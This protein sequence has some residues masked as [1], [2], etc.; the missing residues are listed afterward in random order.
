MSTT[1]TIRETLERDLNQR[2]EEIIKLDQQDERSDVDRRR[3]G[4][5]HPGGTHL[6][7]LHAAS[8]LFH[9]FFGSIQLFSTS[10]QQ[11]DL[12]TLLCEL[13]CSGPSNTTGRTG[14]NN[15]LVSEFVFHK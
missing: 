15:Y 8:N 2:I 5:A 4:A 7:Q 10:C 6:S 12:C 13:P 1:M 9:F 11:S 3:G 14:N